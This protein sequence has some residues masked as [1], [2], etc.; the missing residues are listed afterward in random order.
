MTAATDRRARCCSPTAGFPAGGHAHSGGLEAAVGGR[1]GARPGDPGRRSCAAGCA[2]A[3]LVAAAFAAAARRPRR[4]RPPARW[5]ALDAELD[6]RTAVARRCAVASP[7]P[8]PRAAAGRPRDCGR[9]RALADRRPPRRTSRS[10]SALVAAAGRAATRRRGRAAPRYGAVTGAGQR[11]G[12]AARPRPVRG[13]RRAGRARRRR[14][15]A[16][17]TPAAAAAGDRGRRCRPP[18][19][20]SLDIAAEHHADLGGASL[21]VLTSR[22]DPHDGTTARRTTART[23]TDADPHAAPPATGRALRIGIGGPV[24]RGKTALVAALCRALGRRAAR[25]AWSP[26]TSTPPRTPTSCGAARR[27]RRRAHPRGRDRLLPAHRD[28][29]RHHRQPRRGRGPRGARSA[30]STWCWSRAAATTSPPPSAR[31][32]STAD[33]RD[34]R[35]RRRQGA[36]QGRPR[37]HHAPTCW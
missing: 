9:G 33:L 7:A 23:P 25:S 32:W 21:C 31:A 27:A 18:A 1:P 16:S 2:T 12:A 24:G 6:A 37:R 26:T 14:R 35:G 11:G 10:C 3:G 28:P 5:P 8:G 22:H 34:R 29:R 36:A 30:R 15:R 13:A 4:R 17:P 20:R 19:P